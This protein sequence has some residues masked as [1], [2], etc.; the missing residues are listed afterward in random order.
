MD[1]LLTGDFLAEGCEN[2]GRRKEQE[3][4]EDGEGI[5]G[6]VYCHYGMNDGQEIQAPASTLLKFPKLPS[7]LGKW[8]GSEIKSEAKG[9]RVIPQV[10]WGGKHWGGI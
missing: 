3:K 1:Q 6:G 2:L 4:N 8:A 10:C 7:S 9:K 5:R